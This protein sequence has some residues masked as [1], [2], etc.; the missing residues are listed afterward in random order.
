MHVRLRPDDEIART[1]KVVRRFRPLQRGRHPQLKP[2]GAFGKGLSFDRRCRLIPPSQGV[3]PET[4]RLT[5]C[6]D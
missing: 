2:S 1:G 6:S 3:V 4:L 5:C